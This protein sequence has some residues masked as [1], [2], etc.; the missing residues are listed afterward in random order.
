MSQ[1]QIGS[2]EQ[3]LA[4]WVVYAVLAAPMIA[5]L[6][7]D[8]GVGPVAAWVSYAIIA[9]P[10]I[11][12]LSHREIN[13]DPLL[14]WVLYTAQKDVCGLRGNVQAIFCRR[15]HQPRRHPPARVMACS[16]DAGWMRVREALETLREAKKAPA[17]LL[18]GLQVVLISRCDTSKGLFP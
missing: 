16:P 3:R 18:P 8:L 7:R 1:I 12:M 9:A 17:S 14:R 6:S 15:R 11:A 4:R 5:T 2:A 10:M 13:V